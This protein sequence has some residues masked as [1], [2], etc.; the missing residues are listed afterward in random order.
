MITIF[1]KYTEIPIIEPIKYNEDFNEIIKM[2]DIIFPDT[3]DD[4]WHREY[5][6]AVDKNIFKNNKQEQDISNMLERKIITFKH[7]VNQF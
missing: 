7:Y 6:D 5:L 1:E 4:N 3:S 2:M